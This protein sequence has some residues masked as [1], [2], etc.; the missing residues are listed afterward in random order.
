MFVGIGSIIVL[1]LDIICIM[2]VVQ[3]GM[4]STKKLIWV[5]VILFLPVLGPILWLLI[6]RGG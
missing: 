5:L 1:I 4:D 6:G 2:Q 3:S